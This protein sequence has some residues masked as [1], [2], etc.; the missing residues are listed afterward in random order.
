MLTQFKPNHRIHD[1]A[2]LNHPGTYNKGLL[3]DKP[4]K[5][6]GFNLRSFSYREEKEDGALCSN[7]DINKHECFKDVRREAE[8]VPWEQCTAA[9]VMYTSVHICT[10]GARFMNNLDYLWKSGSESKILFVLGRTPEPDVLQ[11]VHNTGLKQGLKAVARGPLVAHVTPSCGLHVNMKK[12][13]A[14]W[15]LK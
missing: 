3:P 4:V 2:Q 12:Y 6:P 1:E 5:K 14:V 10:D 15:S 13:D 11:A 7:K 8:T 9:Q